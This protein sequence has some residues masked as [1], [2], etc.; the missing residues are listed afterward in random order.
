MNLDLSLKILSVC[1][2]NTTRSV[3]LEHYLKS[4]G[5]LHIVSAGLTPVGFANPL[6]EELL[7]TNGIQ[8]NLDDP[9]G[10]DDIDIGDFD[11]VI[12]L[13]QNG[14]ERLKDFKIK[15]DLG[16]AELE[17]WD[18]AAPPSFGEVSRAQLL[19]AYS[20]LYNDI[21]AHTKNRFDV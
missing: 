20:R 15:G 6:V 1:N 19:D 10:L 16:D 11:V 12:A 5:F 8:V 9:R 18:I 13:S 21:K 4:L 2:E 17:Y 14:Y 3:L 7:K